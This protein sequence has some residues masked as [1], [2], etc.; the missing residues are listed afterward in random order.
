MDQVHNRIDIV[1]DGQGW[2]VKK[3]GE[4][5]PQSRHRFLEAAERAAQRLLSEEGG[6]E[7]WFRD[8]D[9]VVRDAE[10]VA[11]APA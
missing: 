3:S 6:G 7:V 1:P 9:G 5:A 11:P 10:I 2:A 4:A 8:R